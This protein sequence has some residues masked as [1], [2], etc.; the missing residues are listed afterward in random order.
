MI[1][2]IAVGAILENDLRQFTKVIS[3]KRGLYGISGWTSKANAEKATVAMQ[4]L[5]S[6]GM[7]F[8]NIRVVKTT[9]SKV[10]PLTRESAKSAKPT[11]AQLNKMSAADVKALADS[12]GIKAP[13]K[14]EA[15]ENILKA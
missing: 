11:E 7:K 10:A 14:K 5:N 2:K 8:A 13:T 6:F 12:M 15:I 3:F 9:G 4:F 1:N